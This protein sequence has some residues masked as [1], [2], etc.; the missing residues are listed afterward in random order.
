VL[1]AALIV[2]GAAH[3][4]F[5]LKSG[6]SNKYF[7]RSVPF[8]AAAHPYAAYRLPPIMPRQPAVK[9]R[10][11]PAPPPRSHQWRPVGR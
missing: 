4:F 7:G 5:C 8:A 9:H 2:P 1:V 3:A 10:A 11:R 6:S